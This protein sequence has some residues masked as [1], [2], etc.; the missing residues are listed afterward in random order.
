MATNDTTAT[1]Q[2]IQGDLK[3]LRNDVSK[4]AEQIASLLSVGGGEELGQVKDRVRQM[5][6]NLGD[7]VTDA[8]ERSREAFGDV[9]ENLGQAI[10]SSLREHPITTVAL[11]VGLG[12]LFGTTWRR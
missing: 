1:V 7:A 8:S 3:Q 12:F 2:E 10:E 11:A 6:D 4:L 5:R 9:S